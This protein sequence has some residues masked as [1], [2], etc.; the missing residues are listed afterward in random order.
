M[1]KYGR[2]IS[3]NSVIGGAVKKYDCWE[4]R[5]AELPYLS[6]TD[7]VCIASYITLPRTYN[8]LFI[9]FYEDVQSFQILISL[10][11]HIV[12]SCFF[13]P[14]SNVEARG[15]IEDI[16]SEH[17]DRRKPNAFPD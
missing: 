16:R 6:G 2:S 4:F 17:V 13:I 12:Y 1:Q 15:I 7:M 9:G 8:L 11:N 5:Y 3:M 14:S 10:T